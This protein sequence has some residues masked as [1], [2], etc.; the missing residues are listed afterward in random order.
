MAKSGGALKAKEV[1]ARLRAMNGQSFA[2][3]TEVNDV[4]G[5]T[6]RWADA[7][8]M[9]LWQ[10][11]GIELHGYEVK[12]SRGDWLRELKNPEKADAVCKYCD[13]WWIVCGLSGIVKQDELPETWGLM[14]PHGT[15]LRTVV[16]AP[17]LDPIAIDRKF[18]ASIFRRAAEQSADVGTIKAASD[19]SYK[20]GYRDGEMRQAER[21]SRNE[22]ILLRK[23]V[24][25]FEK[26]SGVKIGSYA[27]RHYGEAFAAVLRGEHRRDAEGL[28][29]IQEFCHDT[30]K[31]I[32]KIKANPAIVG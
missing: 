21:Q 27:G 19:E 7:V 9:C 16:K 14:E 28:K 31:E 23:S 24:D 8:G 5:G 17:K 26:A 13:R 12:V 15:T 29:R 22:D 3:L 32:D 18:L 25:E 4:P 10:S 6:G 1:I 2:I 30:I 20:R 11:R